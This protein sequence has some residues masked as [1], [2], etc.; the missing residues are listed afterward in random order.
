MMWRAPGRRS[1]ER[2]K[3][4]R[5]MQ[6]VEAVR[7]RDGITKT[8]LAAELGANVDGVRAWMTGRTIG[9]KETVAKIEDFLERRA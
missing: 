6:K 3:F 5:L 9:R 4:R 1:A 8:E 2:E 7:E